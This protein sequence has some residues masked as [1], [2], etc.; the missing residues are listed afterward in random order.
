M[1]RFNAYFKEMDKYTAYSSGN[2]SIT[3]GNLLQDIKNVVSLKTKILG[4]H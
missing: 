3:H 1:D 2:I 4:R